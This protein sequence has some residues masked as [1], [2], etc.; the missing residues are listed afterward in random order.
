M[1]EYVNLM[2]QSH[3]RH[4]DKRT[5]ESRSTRN[6]SDT[7]PINVSVLADKLAT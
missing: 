4:C 3:T 5:K 2:G 6:C 7:H 1:I